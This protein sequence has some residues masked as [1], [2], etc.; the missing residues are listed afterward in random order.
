MIFI[1]FK[2]YKWNIPTLVAGDGPCSILSNGLQKTAAGKRKAELGDQTSI[3]D[4]HR[5]IETICRALRRPN[6]TCLFK[7]KWKLYT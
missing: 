1:L 4:Q 5:A 7:G 2:F 6:Q 3:E